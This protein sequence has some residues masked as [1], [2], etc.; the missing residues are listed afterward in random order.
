VCDKLRNA[1]FYANSKKSMFFAERVEILGHIIDED[2]LHPAAEKLR[3]IMDQ[4][5]P[6]KQKDLQCFNGMANNIL[7]FLPHAAIRTSPLT[8]LTGNIEWQ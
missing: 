5:R 4:T 1:G 3:S 7:Q 8:E 6:K 2:G